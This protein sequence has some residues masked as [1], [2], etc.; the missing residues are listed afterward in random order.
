[1]TQHRKESWLSSNS[2]SSL[3]LLVITKGLAGPMVAHLKD[4]ISQHSLQLGMAM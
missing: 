4:Y 2:Y 1:M 3:F